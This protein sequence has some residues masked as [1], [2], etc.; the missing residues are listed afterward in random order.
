LPED[1]K[2]FAAFAYVTGMRKG[3]VAS[4]AWSDVEGDV[5]T[6]RGEN[7]K[8]DEARTIPLVGELGEIVKRRQAARRLEEN[9]TVRMVEFI[10][11]RDGRA[12]PEFR[13]SWATACKKAGVARHF[14]DFRRSAVRNMT[15]AGVPQAVAMKI[16]RHKT[17]SMFQ[18]YSIVT[19]DDLRTALEKP[20]TFREG[21]T[22][23]VVSISK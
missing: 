11:H 20:E 12:G 23:N 22:G 7:S 19:T 8:N 2:D 6:L 10:F 21:S 4:L 18:G 13:R 14:H 3:E 15:Q 5:L 17:A 9:G 1:L 16:S